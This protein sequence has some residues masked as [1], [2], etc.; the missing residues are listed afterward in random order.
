MMDIAPQLLKEIQEAFNLQYVYDEDLMKLLSDIEN[1]KAA[2]F[3]D[4]QK[5][6]DIIGDML[7]KAYENTLSKAELPNDRLF[8]NICDKVYVGE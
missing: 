2:D 6:A 8:E 7:G 4:A 5:Y 1:G 3:R